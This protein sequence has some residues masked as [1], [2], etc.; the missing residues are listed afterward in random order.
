MKR[1]EMLQA[2]AALGAASITA[3][4]KDHDDKDDKRKHKKRITPMDVVDAA[5]EWSR[6]SLD[7]EE[8]ERQSLELLNVVNDWR[9]QYGD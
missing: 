9:D 3:L 6:S 2:V 7:Q 5:V 1:R 8:F 4:A